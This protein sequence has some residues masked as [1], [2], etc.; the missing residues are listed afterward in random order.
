METLRTCPPIGN[1]QTPSWSAHI[2]TSQSVATLLGLIV[3]CVDICR[4]EA[5]DKS[6]SH[7][8]SAFVNAYTKE[9]NPTIWVTSPGN[10]NV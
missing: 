2:I 7:N 5:S 9:L 6:I 4:I 10:E 1:A 3:P 8:P